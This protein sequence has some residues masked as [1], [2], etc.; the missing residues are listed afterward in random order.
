VA[1]AGFALMVRVGPGSSYLADVL[2]AVLV[3]ALGF[4]LTVAPLTAT[5]LAAAGEE[6]AG[7]ASAVNNDVARTAGLMAVALLP[8]AVGIA[9]SDYAHPAAFSAGFH[10]AALVTAGLCVVGGLLA[11]AGVRN[12]ALPVSRTPIHCPVSGPP[13]R[14]AAAST[15]PS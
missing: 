1:G 3:M 5:A 6:N 13:L 14:S 7:L 12:P 11:G 4:A 9:Q 10:R 8:V 2:P 15:T